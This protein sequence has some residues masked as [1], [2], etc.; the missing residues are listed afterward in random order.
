[1][2]KREKEKWNESADI[3]QGLTWSRVDVSGRNRSG[4]G[5]WGIACDREQDIFLFTPLKIQHFVDPSTHC[6]LLS[7]QSTRKASYYFKRARMPGMDNVLMESQERQRASA[8]RE[9]TRTHERVWRG[10]GVG[11]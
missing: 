2:R 11:A 1:M 5:E 6:F 3:F 4:E 10:C 9:R 8:Q 7:V